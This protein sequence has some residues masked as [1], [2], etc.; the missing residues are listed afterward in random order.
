MTYFVHLW[1]LD[2]YGPLEYTDEMVL[3]WEAP[4]TFT[5]L[6]ADEHCR[7]ITKRV[8]KQIR[9]LRPREWRPLD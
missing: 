9:S 4:D 3:G 1:I 2:G 7:P 5:E 6:E 8:I